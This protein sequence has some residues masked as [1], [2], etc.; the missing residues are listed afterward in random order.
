MKRNNYMQYL[1]L[2]NTVLKNNLN[3]ISIKNIELQNEIN[4]YKYKIEELYLTNANTILILQEKINYFNKLIIEKNKNIN[5]IHSSQ[6][7]QLSEPEPQSEPGL[8]PQTFNTE[9]E[10]TFEY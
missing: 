9:S 5:P 1:L 8:D 2:E 3:I 4:N 7:F 6:L 10:L